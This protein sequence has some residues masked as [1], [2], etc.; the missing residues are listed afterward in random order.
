MTTITNTINPTTTGTDITALYKTPEGAKIVMAIYDDALK[1]WPIPYETRMITTRHGDTFV[2]ASEGSNPAAPAVILLH[3]AGGNSTM[4]ASDVG[5]FSQ[6]YRVF[7]TDLPG[8][9]GKSAPNRPAWDGPAFAEWLE[10]VINGLK[11]DRVTLVALSQGGWTALKFA[12]TAPDRVEKLVLLSPGGIVPDRPTFLLRA[13]AT[14]ILGKRVINRF[15]RSL[16]GD[17]QV[18]DGVIEITARISSQFKPRIGIVPIFTD[19]EL[20]QLTMPVLLIGGTKDIVRDMDKIAA[21]LRD[22]LPNLTVQIIAGA[23]HALI[24]TGS[25]V[26]AFLAQ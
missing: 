23:G 26:M 21:R 24:D 16:F 5:K 10:D 25:R 11:L 22:L 12:V 4:W 17:Q 14:S 15:M 2:I 8:E 6:R 3:G 9:A 7:A 18:P 13:I 1:N 20:R 19:A